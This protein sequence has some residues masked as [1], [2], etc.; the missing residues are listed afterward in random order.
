MLPLIYHISLLKGRRKGVIF[1]DTVSLERLSKIQTFC[2]DSRVTEEALDKIEETGVIPAKNPTTE[3]D[4]AIYRTKAELEA[5]KEPVFKIAMGF[6]SV[7][8]NLTVYDSNTERIASAI[9]LSRTYKSV[10]WENT[11]YLILGKLALIT[12]AFLLGITPALAV[13]I[14]FAVWMIC[15][16]N[17]TKKA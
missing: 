7:N 13:I 17:A 10:F 15:L 1:R 5:Q 16:I 6:F 3:F 2:P 11:V 4:A 9:R 8:A 14:E 12:L